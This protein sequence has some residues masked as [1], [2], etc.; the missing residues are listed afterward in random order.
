MEFEGYDIHLIY[1]ARDTLINNISSPLERMLIMHVVLDINV[2]CSSYWHI[3]MLTLSTLMKEML[4]C[5]LR[6]VYSTC[7]SVLHETWV[8][9]DVEIRQLLIV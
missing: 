2:C 8:G 1:R 9:L 7:M 5:I 3:L 6:Y 4:S